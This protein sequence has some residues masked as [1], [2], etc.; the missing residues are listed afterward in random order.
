MKTLLLILMSFST[1]PIF[2]Q[3]T[4]YDVVSYTP[5][6]GW[7]QETGN[8]YVSYSRIDGG[9]WAQMAIYK[10]TSSKGDINSDS[11]SEWQAI[12]LAA[13]T[14]EKEEKTKP[15]TA[16]GWTVM[17]R[18]G[19][20]Q[21]NGANVATIL[22]TYSNGQV[23]VSILFNATARPY[24]NDY[25]KFLSEVSM[26]SGNRVSPDSPAAPPSLNKPATKNPPPEGKYKFTTTH[27]DDGWT[28]AEKAD[29]VEVSKPGIRVLIHY[30]DQKTDAHHFE[31]LKGDRNA[32]DVLVSPR[33]RNISDLQQ[34]GIQGSPSITFFTADA[35]DKQSGKTS[36]IVLYKKHYDQGNG[37]YLEV[38]AD[39]RAVFEKEFGNNYINTS[40]WNYQE[41][42][43]S[44]DKLAEMQWRNKFAVSPS[45]LSGKWSS[46]DFASLS[47]YYVSSGRYAGST[48]TA[49]SDEYIFSGGN[50][51]S[52]QHSGASGQV[53]NMGFSTQ[54]YNGRYT[55]TDWTITLS[56]RV[57]GGY[58]TF[59]C[60]FEA[61]KGGR[62][63]VLTD[64]DNTVKSMVRQQ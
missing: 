57:Q 47:Y 16:D 9:S 15:E 33:Y 4:T 27:F 39:N 40:S 31:K 38:V 49:I 21:Y 35:T 28:A 61:V 18:S 60:R 55:L 56:N 25:K 19:V 17:S 22:T 30:P 43:K 29:W 3:K 10:S 58:E 52:S 44:W 24:F 41:Q 64:H 51:Y 62:I 7:K 12:V 59:N 20:W 36:F 32:W 1:T 54:K 46:T 50:S 14:M 23:C 13:H 34:R 26:L 42:S 2:A 8:N 37:R 45:D 11:D 63:L 53:G 6:A 5:P 48:A